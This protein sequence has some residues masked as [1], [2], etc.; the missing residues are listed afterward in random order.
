[1]DYVA[2]KAFTYAGKA[3]ARGDVWEPSGARVDKLLIAQRTVV[4]PEQIAPAE[5]KKLRGRKVAS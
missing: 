1:M 2:A 3:Y 5:P 4:A